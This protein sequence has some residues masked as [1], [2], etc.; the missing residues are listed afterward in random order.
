MAGKTK[1]LF[2]AYVALEILVAAGFGAAIA[3]AQEKPWA[4]RPK[5]EVKR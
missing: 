2:W 1:K 4:R 3:F 5:G